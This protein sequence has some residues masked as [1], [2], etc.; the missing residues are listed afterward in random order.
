M[1]H[2]GRG[3]YSTIRL[4]LERKQVPGPAGYA[5]KGVFWALGELFVLR[6]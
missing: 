2:G 3:E 5:L 1:V 6:D 4:E